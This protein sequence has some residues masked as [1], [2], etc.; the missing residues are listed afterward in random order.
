MVSIG[1]IISEGVPRMLESMQDQA[2]PRLQLL[3]MQCISLILQR[4]VRD[5]KPISHQVVLIRIL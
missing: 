3:S 2:D 5:A 1:D 4:T